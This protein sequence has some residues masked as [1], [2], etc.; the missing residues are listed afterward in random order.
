MLAN[1]LGDVLLLIGVLSISF[2]LYTDMLNDLQ[3]PGCPLSRAAMK[4]QRA[5]DHPLYSTIEVYT[6]GDSHCQHEL[7]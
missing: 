1:V 3:A 2:D 4:L 7:T 6:R 5:P